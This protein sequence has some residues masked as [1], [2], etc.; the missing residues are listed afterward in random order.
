MLIRLRDEPELE[1][2]PLRDLVARPLADG[3][4]TWFA[5]YEAVHRENVDVVLG[6]RTAPSEP[7][8]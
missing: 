6:R 2:T 5:P 3:A 4:I 8:A 1:R 7:V